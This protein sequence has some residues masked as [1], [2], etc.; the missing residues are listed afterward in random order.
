MRESPVVLSLRLVLAAGHLLF[1]PRLASAGVGTCVE[2]DGTLALCAPGELDL[3][4]GWTADASRRRRG[5]LREPRCARRTSRGVTA[6]GAQ[7]GPGGVASDA[8]RVCSVTSV[9]SFVS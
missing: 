6:G 2:P 8:S 5:D 4:S 3:T 9:Q 7:A 1:L